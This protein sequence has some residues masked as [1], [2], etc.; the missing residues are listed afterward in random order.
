[1]TP[2]HRRLLAIVVVVAGVG[3]ATTLALRAFRENLL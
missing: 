2:R 3:I 1:M